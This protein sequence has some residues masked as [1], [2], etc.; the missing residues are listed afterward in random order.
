MWGPK[1]VVVC[2]HP[3]SS[4]VNHPVDESQAVRHKHRDRERGGVHSVATPLPS[5]LAVDGVF[6]RFDG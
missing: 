6:R 1:E 2:C 4:P 5:P 3:E